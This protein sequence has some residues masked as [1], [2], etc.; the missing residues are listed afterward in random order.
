MKKVIIGILTVL[1]IV[2]VTIFYMRINETAE[3]KNKGNKLIEK[4]ESYRQRHGELPD[5]VT[6]LGIEEEMGEGPYYEK[7][8]SVKYIVYFNIGFD[9]SFIYYSDTKKWEWTP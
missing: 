7:I 3:Y 8:D 9:N 1:I 4:I 5:Y 6:E 2:T